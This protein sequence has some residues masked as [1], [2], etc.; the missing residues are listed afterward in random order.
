MSCSYYSFKG[1]IFGDYWCNKT[2]KRVDSETYRR[3]CRDYNYSDCSVYK[4]SSSSGCYLTTMVCNVLKKED[5]DFVLDIMRKFRDNYLQKNPKY[6]DLLKA[7]DNIG[8]MIANNIYNDKD[9]K[10]L[11]QKLYDNVLLDISVDIINKNYLD[12][13][14]KYQKMTTFLTAYYN[15]SDIYLTFEECNYGFDK[16][17]KNRLGHGLQYANKSL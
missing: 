3:Y 11:S 13:V 9:K 17:E 8:P 1:G 4:Q 14:K 10:N 6:Y 15:L 2:D 5:N 12:A 16:V 7:Y